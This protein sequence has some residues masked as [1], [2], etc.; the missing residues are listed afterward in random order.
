MKYSLESCDDLARGN[1]VPAE[2]PFQATTTARAFF[3]QERA[4]EFR[5]YRV[6]A[7]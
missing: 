3:E 2:T 7:E 6:R 1:W 5:F 4:A